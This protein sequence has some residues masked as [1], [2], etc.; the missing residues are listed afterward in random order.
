M[1]HTLTPTPNGSIHN[2]SGVPGRRG[3]R[4]SPVSEHRIKDPTRH[5]RSNS[6]RNGSSSCRRNSTSS[7]AGS[8]HAHHSDHPH[9]HGAGGGAGGTS[10]AH[11]RHNHPTHHTS[12]GLGGMI[13]MRV[14]PPSVGVERDSSSC[15]SLIRGLFCVCTLFIL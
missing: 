10:T 6:D 11:S 12:S 3:A 13:F 14:S 4:L 5:S 2:A 1:S 15:S 7:I 9:E 8:H